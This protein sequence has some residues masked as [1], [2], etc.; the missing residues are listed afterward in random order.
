M[1]Q[2]IS[3]VLFVHEVISRAKFVEYGV[4]IAWWKWNIVYDAKMTQIKKHIINIVQ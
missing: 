4:Q 3:V 2:K 1:A